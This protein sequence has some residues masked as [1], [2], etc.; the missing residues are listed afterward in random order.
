MQIYHGEVILNIWSDGMGQFFSLGI[1]TDKLVYFSY[2]A[3]LNKSL[4]YFIAS[5][6]H[7]MKPRNK[8]Y[9]LV[10]ENLTGDTLSHFYVLPAML[11]VQIEI[12]GSNFFSRKLEME[13][14]SVLKAYCQ[15]RNLQSDTDILPFVSVV[16]AKWG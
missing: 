8:P 13:A 10:A 11:L 9:G 12:P 6:T 5:N 2:R 7:K 16:T 1:N 3:S 14:W 4:L 15:G